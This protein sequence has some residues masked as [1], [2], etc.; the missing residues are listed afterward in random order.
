MAY[1]GKMVRV[2]EEASRI[3]QSAAGKRLG[4]PDLPAEEGHKQLHA[5]VLVEARP[6]VVLPMVGGFGWLPDVSID[7]A[8]EETAG[9]SADSDQEA[10]S[11][12]QDVEI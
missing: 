2:R 3:L 7:A 10:A 5:A 6:W 4:L 9:E 8:E 12:T 1:N 11:S